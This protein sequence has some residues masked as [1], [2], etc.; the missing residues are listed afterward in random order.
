MCLVLVRV[1][2]LE[3]MWERVKG[4]LVVI[5]GNVQGDL[6]MLME[7]EVIDENLGLLFECNSGG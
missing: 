1:T 5:Y 2:Y 4:P 6:V 7:G 3:M